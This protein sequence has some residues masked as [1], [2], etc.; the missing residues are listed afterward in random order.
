M[1]ASTTVLEKGLH[2][3]QTQTHT[4]KKTIQAKQSNSDEHTSVK[5]TSP[6]YSLYLVK[7][8]RDGLGLLRVRQTSEHN[9]RQGRREAAAAKINPAVLRVKAHVYLL[10]PVT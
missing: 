3:T 9:L 10:P 1:I 5:R 4:K 2:E 8:A 6:C 7:G